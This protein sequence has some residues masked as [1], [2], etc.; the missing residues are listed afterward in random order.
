MLVLGRK[1]DEKIRL[2]HKETGEQV[3]LT[4]V[5]MKGNGVRI[6]VD[7]ELHWDISRHDSRGRCQS[8]GPSNKAR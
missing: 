7:C 2:T 8:S 5:K 6:G 4:I 1:E 3:E